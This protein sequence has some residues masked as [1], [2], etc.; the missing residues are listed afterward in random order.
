[1]K[2]EIENGTYHLI[3][4]TNK[5]VLPP[6][7]ITLLSFSFGLFMHANH[8]QCRIMHASKEYEQI[9]GSGYDGLSLFLLALS[10]W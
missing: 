3:P 10:E 2:L 9:P 7:Y 1:M 5:Q 8:K 6:M 4:D